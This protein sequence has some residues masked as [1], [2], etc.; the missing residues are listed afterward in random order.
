MTGSSDDTKAADA[1]R[2]ST[3]TSNRIGRP[4]APWAAGAAGV[5]LVVVLV[6]GAAR[7]DWAMRRWDASGLDCGRGLSTGDPEDLASLWAG[8]GEGEHEPVDDLDL[9]DHR[10]HIEE[11]SAQLDAEPVGEIPVHASIPAQDDSQV[12]VEVE[13]EAQGGLIRADVRGEDGLHRF[14]AIAP[15]S[16]TPVWHWDLDEGR[17]AWMAQHGEHLVMANRIVRGHNEFEGDLW[18]DMLSLDAASG[19]REGCQRFA[20]SPGYGAGSTDAG[21]VVGTEYWNAMVADEEQEVGTR[22]IQQV[23][24][25]TFSEGFDR[26]LPALEYESLE[27]MSRSRPQG[28]VTLPGGVF[29]TYASPFAGDGN[30]AFMQARNDLDFPSGTV[31]VEAFSMDTGESLWSYGEPGDRV[32]FVSGVHAVPDDTSGV[33]L[34][35]LGEFEPR[36]DDPERGTSP[37]TLRMLD[38][39]GKQLWEVDAAD[40]GDVFSGASDSERYLRV[41]GDVIL[42]H[43]A[44]HEVTALDAAT[45]EAL[46]S[47]DEGE[48]EPQPLWLHEAVS[49]DGHLFLPGYKRDHMVDARTGEAEDE[50]AAAMVDAR[51]ADATALGEDM[52]LVETWD[53]GHVILRKR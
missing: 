9:E 29:L 19:E 51:V 4:W 22:T 17:D 23:T 3:D 15:S 43:T 48:A 36:T 40:I 49:V 7:P 46:W 28:L 18:T 44:P 26:T 30:D 45:G 2:E 35:E 6:L 32:A 34:A 52:L 38:A 1:V 47:I 20:G 12:T 13:V 41:L 42:V 39:E 37:V 14:A 11:L 24:L 27:G 31:P 5:L 8:W 10:A 16:G 33:L 21:L 50:L 53:Y 25:P